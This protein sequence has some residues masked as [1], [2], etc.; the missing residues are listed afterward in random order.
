M[1]EHEMLVNDLMDSG[2]V[3]REQAEKIVNAWMTELLGLE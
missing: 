1:T 3:D 2:I